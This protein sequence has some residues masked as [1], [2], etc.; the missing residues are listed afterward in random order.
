METYLDDEQLR[1]A[2]AA[3]AEIAFRKYSIEE[4]TSKYESLFREVLATAARAPQAQVLER[5]TTSF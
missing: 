1:K 2:H 4:C 3:T 5:P